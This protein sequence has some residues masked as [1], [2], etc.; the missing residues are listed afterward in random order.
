MELIEGLENTKKISNEIAVK[1][2]QASSTQEIIKQTSEKYRVVANRSALLFFLMNDLVKI[3][4]YY[5][6]SLEAFTTVFY[7]GIDIVTAIEGE[8]K[9]PVEI[10]E[11][12]EAPAEEEGDGELT[13]E[14]LAA[15]CIVLIGSITTTVFNYVRKCVCLICKIDCVFR[16]I[17]SFIV[18][19]IL[20]V[21]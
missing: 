8:V 20:Y 1:Q 21:S 5:I 16:I 6:Y 15:R 3:H 17:Y 10:E 12:K 11:G 4:T 14:Q 7:R 19:V 13:D 18:F 9:E 2:V